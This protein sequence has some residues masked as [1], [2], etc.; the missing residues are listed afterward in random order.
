[1]HKDPW[2]FGARRAPHQPLHLIAFLLIALV[3]QAAA[4]AQP[5]SG[6][7]IDRKTQAAIIDS[8]IMQQVGD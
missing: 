8:V 5:D 7:P 2:S 4:Q 3:I 1:M 6:P